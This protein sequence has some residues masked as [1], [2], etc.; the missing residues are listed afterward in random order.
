MLEAAIDDLDVDTLSSELPEAFALLDRLQAK[1]T[2]AA[3]AFDREK[4][5]ELDAAGSMTSWLRG[6]AGRAHVD[7][8][9]TRSTARRLHDLPV[10]STAWMDG[11]LSTAQVGTITANVND[12]TVGLFADSEAT[13]LP[14]LADCNERDAAEM[15]RE[16][17]RHANEL[18]PDP[19]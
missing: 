10:T 18:F 2:M 5:W 13:L 6:F 7:A 19:D 9:K 4:R 1:L 17:A 16:W 12:R 3:G 15:M 11:A 8:P 14:A